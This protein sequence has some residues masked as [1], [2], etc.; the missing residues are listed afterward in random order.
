M[1]IKYNNCCSSRLC[2]SACDEIGYHKWTLK[3]SDNAHRS[4][5]ALVRTGD[6]EATAINN[7][8]TCTIV[9]SWL[10]EAAALRDVT[11]DAGSGLSTSDVNVEDAGLAKQG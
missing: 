11:D 5:R 1:H 8:L 7:A 6:K 9:R 4:T 10:I 2:F 3:T